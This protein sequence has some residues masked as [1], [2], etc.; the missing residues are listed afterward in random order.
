M[1]RL[2]TFACVSLLLAFTLASFAQQ[3]QTPNP[4]SLQPVDPND[5]I[6][7]MPTA[8]GTTTPTPQ[9]NSLAD[10]ARK[11]RKEHAPEVKMTDEQTKELFA[12]I[13]KILDFA[14]TDTGYAKRSSVK[15]QMVT[16]TDIEQ[17]TKDSLAKAEYSQRFA[18]AELTMKK[19]GLLPREFDLKDF[20]IKANG[21]QVAGL[22][23]EETKTISLLNTVSLE[24]Q[25]PIL[26]HELTHAL[27]DQNFDLKN[28][29]RPNGKNS[30]TEEASTA[31]H[32]IVEGQ[33][34]VVYFDYA[35]APYGRSLQSTPGI[36][37]SMEEP[38][39]QASIDTEMLHNAP[40]VL[41]EAGAFPYRDGL[42]FEAEVLEKAGKQ[43]A[44]AGVF[45][46]PP[47]STHEVFDPKAYL[48]HEKLAPVA[49]P[50]VRSLLANQ[51]EVYD[52]GSFGELDVRSLLRQFGDHRTMNELA[53]NW[54]GG[55]YVTFKKSA[56]SNPQPVTSD[57]A[58]LY[59]SHWKTTQA[60]EKF[61]RFYATSVALRYPG[62]TVQNV[63]ACAASPCPTGA[64]L[65]STSEGP[66]VV[67]EWP[68]NSV[69]VSESFDTALAAKLSG[70]IR[71]A[72]SEEHASTGQS[73]PLVSA[74]KADFDDELTPR[75]FAMPA[76]A[77]F[78]SQV[79]D[80]LLANLA[81]QAAISKQAKHQ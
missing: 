23:N 43:A 57:V 34:M 68:D 25:G 20:L 51:Y 64:A 4:H 80:R 45:A 36:V 70:A 28:W 11:L 49:I 7:G 5:T 17:F 79:A 62:A 35:L 9:Q 77:A 29:A 69:I 39:V 24:Q 31:R 53:S 48:D 42:I 1:N 58:L 18:R 22:Y 66:V 76:F 55:T 2:R 67:E 3:N 63:P 33:A 59:V 26:A 14:S 37:A 73:W 30:V 15:R 27:Q 74:D 32:A 16:P 46:H 47:R 19:F 6:P 38:A 78:Q 41:R 60:A 61:A 81:A 12:S 54:Q 13:D 72:H 8:S 75:L 44:F 71:T 65:V 52:S 50:D 21:K 56:S 10:Q 40:M